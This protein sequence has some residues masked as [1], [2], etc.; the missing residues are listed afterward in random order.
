MQIQQGAAAAAKAAYS[1]CSKYTSCYLCPRRRRCPAAAG[2]A[3]KVPHLL[4]PTNFPE[5]GIY[6]CFCYGGKAFMEAIGDDATLLQLVYL[7]AAEMTGPPK[8]LCF[9]LSLSLSLK[10]SVITEKLYYYTTYN[11][12]F[13]FCLAQRPIKTGRIQRWIV[14]SEST[15]ERE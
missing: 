13:L 12:G 15:A 3:R 1:I 9:P 11:Q 14:V 10:L 7:E 2:A 5:E 4:G 8:Q 6:F